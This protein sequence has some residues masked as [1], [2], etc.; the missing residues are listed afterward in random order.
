LSPS[1][2][3]LALLLPVPPWIGFMVYRARGRVGLSYGYFL[4]G[5]LALLSLPWPQTG[6]RPVP[7]AEMGGALFGFSMFLQAHREGRR[8]LQR[9][10]LGVGGT[11]LFAWLLG[12]QLDLPLRSLW[13]FWAT[14]LVVGSLW[15]LLVDLSYRLTRGRWLHLRIPAMGGVAMALAT[16]LSRFVSA[17]IFPLPWVASLLAGVL[18]GLV[19]LQQLLYLREHGIWVEGRGDGFRVALSALETDQPEEGPSLALAIDAQQP[20]LLV[21]DRGMLLES[22]SAFARMVGL[23][24]HQ[25]R[26]YELPAFFQGR[27]MEVWDDLHE[28]LLRRGHGSTTASL[29]RR[30]GSFDTVQLEA[31]AFDR[32]LALVWMAEQLPGSLALRSDEEGPA[33]LDPGEVTAPGRRATVNALGTIVPAAEQILAETGDDRVREAAELILVAAHRLA[34]ES[35]S[36]A[37]GLVALPRTLSDQLPRLSRMLPRDIRVEV[38]SDT[39]QLQTEADPLRRILTHLVLHGRQGLDRGLILLRAEGHAF[40]GRAWGRISI[41]LEGPVSHRTGGLM[42]LGWLLQATRA[43][44]GILDLR[45]DERGFVWPQ[46]WLPAAG[47]EPPAE[48]QPLRDR[49]VWIVDQDP[50]LREALAGLGRNAGAQ[51]RAFPE[52]RDLLRASRTES[53][54]DLLVMERTSRLERFRRVLHKLHLVPVPMLLVG[55]GSTLMASDPIAFNHSRVAFLEKPFPSANFVDCLMVL[56]HRETDLP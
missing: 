36:H 2:L 33:I 29:V 19:A 54:P 45:R 56:L 28:Q 34:P 41:G 53:A 40:G 1:D 25:L 38:R 22:N 32:N 42:G 24:R 46:V 30:D 10:T 3:L 47:G 50:L 35:A 13:V 15:L 48:D 26:G 52:L 51:T 14:A 9:L 39:L 44:H 6:P 27:N 17:Q 7:I 18:L 16:L 43:C 23:M 37:H 31:A 55:T 21:N 12:G 5:I 4:G 8:G 20:I 11:T 49:R